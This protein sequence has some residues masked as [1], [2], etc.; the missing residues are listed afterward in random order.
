VRSGLWYPI[1]VMGV[2]FVLSLF[3]MKETRGNDL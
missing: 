3:L 1:V 2:C